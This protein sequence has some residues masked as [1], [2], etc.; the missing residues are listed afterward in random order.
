MLLSY[1]IQNLHQASEAFIILIGNKLDLNAERQVKLSD[2]E[3]YAKE[4]KYSFFH[5]YFLF[6]NLFCTFEYLDG[7][8]NFNQVV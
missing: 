2:A 8:V 3:D 7:A 6:Y 4:Q 1:S 5:S